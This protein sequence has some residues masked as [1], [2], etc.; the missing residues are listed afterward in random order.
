MGE[1]DDKET[2]NEFETEF[3]TKINDL[4]N[5]SSN[6]VSKISNLSNYVETSYEVVSNISKYWC[7]EDIETKK[8][9]QELIFSEG[10]SLDIKNRLYLTKKTNV[11]LELTLDIVRDSEG[12][13]NKKATL[14]RM[15]YL[16]AGTGLEPVTFGL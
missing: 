9:I 6:N 1:I 11:I 13:E 15:A 2:Y 4:K 14:F 7:S 16:V 3:E 12:T 8:R 10:L 5:K